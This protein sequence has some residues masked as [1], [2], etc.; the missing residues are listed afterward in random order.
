MIL[1]LRC[2]LFMIVLMAA[3]PVFAHDQ[4]APAMATHALLREMLSGEGY[5]RIQTIQSLE[6]VLRY[7]TP[8][9]SPLVRLGRNTMT[10]RKPRTTYG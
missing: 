7:A 8:S 6:S 4:H 1:N 10:L 3:A 2:M 9:E 5:L